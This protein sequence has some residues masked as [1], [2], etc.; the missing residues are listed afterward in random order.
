MESSIIKTIFRNELKSIVIDNEFEGIISD[1]I[2]QSVNEVQSKYLETDEAMN[3][4]NE[5]KI[6][7]LYSDNPNKCQ[8]IKG[9]VFSKNL[10]DRRMKNNIQNPSILC[11]ACALLPLSDISLTS[12]LHNRI[13]QESMFISKTIDL[14]NEKQANLIFVEQGVH[15][16]LLEKLKDLDKTLVYIY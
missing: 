11:F 6:K 2:I 5:I 4:L 16:K 3:I 7:R 15:A 14:I 13:E 1:I 9:I 8:F 10:A 12:D